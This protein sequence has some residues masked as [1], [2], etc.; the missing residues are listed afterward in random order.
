MIFFFIYFIGDFVRK[1]YSLRV[2]SI[3][4]F[5]TVQVA[6]EALV[7]GKGK[8]QKFSVK[9]V[10]NYKAAM[11]TRAFKSSASHFGVHVSIC[12]S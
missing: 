12:I 7:A 6:L 1:W 8:G 11:R 9:T 10:K 5:G 3:Q 4:A 2:D